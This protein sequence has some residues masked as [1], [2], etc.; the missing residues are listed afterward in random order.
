MNASLSLNMFQSGYTLV[1][2]LV[3]FLSFVLL[4]IPAML[5]PD[6]KPMAVG[7]AIACYFMKSVG[8]LLM[9][10]SLLPLVYNL[11]GQTIPEEKTLY[12]FLAIFVIGLG[13]L[14]YFAQLAADIDEASVVVVRSIFTHGFEILSTIVAFFSGASLLLMFILTERF[15]NWEMPAAMLLLS[16]LTMLLFS[17]HITDKKRKHSARMAKARKK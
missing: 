4:Y 10:I 11:M 9:G 7:Q 1:L 3:I 6:A 5:V 12:A 15:V 13:L 8:I 2:P 16:V 14:V 17:V